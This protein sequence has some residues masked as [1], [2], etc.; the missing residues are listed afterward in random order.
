MSKL[1]NITEIPTIDVMSNYREGKFRF[2]T[3]T[4]L[5]MTC[6]DARN[7][8]QLMK[9]PETILNGY[10]KGALQTVQFQPHEGG[11][12]LTVFSRVGKKVNLIDET[13]MRHIKVG[14][15]NQLFSNTNLYNRDQYKR[16]HSATWDSWAFQMNPPKEQPAG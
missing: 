11:H 16:V 9:H 2:I 5:G 13:I 6:I 7:N 3:K 4:L 10:K 12:W 8:E 15:I 14:T 1:I